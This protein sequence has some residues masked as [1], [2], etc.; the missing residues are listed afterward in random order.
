MDSLE[1]A[2]AFIT[3]AIAGATIA[4]LVVGLIFGGPLR[5]SSWVIALGSVGIGCALLWWWIRTRARTSR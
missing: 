2:V 4:L 3:G 5:G 1:R